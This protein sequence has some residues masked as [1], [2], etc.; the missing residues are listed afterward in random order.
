LKVDQGIE[1][2]S[3]TGDGSGLTGVNADTLES[4]PF[5]YFTIDPEL[6]AHTLAFNI[7]SQGNVSAHHTPTVDTTAA[8]QCSAGELLAGAADGCVT[9]FGLNELSACTD[10][11]VPTYSMGSWGCMAPVTVVSVDII[12]NDQFIRA[13]CPP[14]TTL[15]T[16]GLGGPGCSVGLG[17]A[18]ENPSGSVSVAQTGAQ[19]FFAGVALDEDCDCF[20]VCR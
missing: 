12:P 10:G 6:E 14:G 3:F 1:A 7:H 13:Y 4:F 18:L 20:A 11:D 9:K 5:S 8:T 16:G 19:C 15:L 17:G 2:A